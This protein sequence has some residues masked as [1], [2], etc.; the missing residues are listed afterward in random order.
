MTDKHVHTTFDQVR[1]YNIIILIEFISV[2]LI[3]FNS[4]VFTKLNSILP[5]ICTDNYDI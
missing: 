2:I 3:K 5:L 1:F 4:I